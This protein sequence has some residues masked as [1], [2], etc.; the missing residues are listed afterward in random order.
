[1]CWFGRNL[2]IS[3]FVTQ[4]GRYPLLF[5]LLPGQVILS[6]CD[7]MHRRCLHAPITNT[8]QHYNAVKNA[9]DGD[10]ISRI[11]GTKNCGCGYFSFRTTNAHRRTH[12]RTMRGRSRRSGARG[13][14]KRK[15]GYMRLLRPI[16]ARSPH[17]PH[18]F[19]ETEQ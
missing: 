2:H 7:E 14:S 3:K 4:R 17:Q 5:L 10:W 19:A 8:T 12:V 15:L 13:N 6:T 11:D 18:L 1:M 9:R 16:A